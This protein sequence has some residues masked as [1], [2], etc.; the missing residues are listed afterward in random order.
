MDST[1]VLCPEGDDVDAVDDGEAVVDGNA[2]DAVGQR[3]LCPTVL[4]AEV[5]LVPTLLW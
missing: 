2:V 3:T 1:F 5:A 4:E